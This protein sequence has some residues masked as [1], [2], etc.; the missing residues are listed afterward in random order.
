MMLRNNIMVH[1][2]FKKQQMCKQNA[3]YK[4]DINMTNVQILDVCSG[5]AL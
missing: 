1:Y 3:I 5:N 4:D 2:I